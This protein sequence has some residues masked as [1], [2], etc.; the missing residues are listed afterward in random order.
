MIDAKGEARIALKNQKQGNK[1]VT[2]YWNK[3]RLVASE[4]ELDDSTMREWLLGG[5]NIYLQEAWGAESDEF[6]GMEELARWPMRK[7]TKLTTLQHIQG[8]STTQTVTPRV[9][10]IPRNAN[11]T[12]QTRMTSQEIDTMDLDAFGRRPRLNLSPEEF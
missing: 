7:E 9:N 10:D 6:E 3:F 2:E 11:S 12:Y 4:T 1:S 8:K 5:M